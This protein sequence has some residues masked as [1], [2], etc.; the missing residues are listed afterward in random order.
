MP[1]D[2]LFLLLLAGAG[3][4]AV[5]VALSLAALRAGHASPSELARGL[6][7]GFL[8]ALAL[9][10]VVTALTTV[11]TAGRPFFFGTTATPE[12]ALMLGLLL[13]V[14]IGTGYLAVGSVVMVIGLGVRHSSRW[15]TRDSW[16]VAPAVVVL[17]VAAVGFA[18]GMDE[19]ANRPITRAGTI[20]VSLQGDSIGELRGQG[21]ARCTLDDG[22][23]AVHAGTAEATPLQAADGTRLMVQLGVLADGTPRVSVGAGELEADDARSSGAAL[24]LDPA[25]GRNAGTLAFSGLVP[26]EQQDGQPT[27]TGWS[28]SVSWQ[29]PF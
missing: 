13:G 6:R 20:S 23:L 29:C 18:S 22:N 27:S 19:L 15:A 1:A 10:A 17:G 7:N 16:L 2:P 12:G 26:Y 14:L 21:Q 4:M 25:Y 3:V 28:G 11:L 9:A 5:V 8:I 24:H